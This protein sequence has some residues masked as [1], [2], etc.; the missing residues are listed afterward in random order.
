MEEYIINEIMEK[1][2]SYYGLAYDDEECEKGCYINDLWFS[3]NAIK[4][5][6]ENN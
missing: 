1:I 5:I 4:N 6:L 2:Y 3:I